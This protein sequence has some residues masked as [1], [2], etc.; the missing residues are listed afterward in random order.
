LFKVRVW[1]P[2]VAITAIVNMRAKMFFIW[3]LSTSPNF[4]TQNFFY[5]YRTRLSSSPKVV[6]LFGSMHLTQLAS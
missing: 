3:Y 4:F 2:T 5:V 1:A 6:A